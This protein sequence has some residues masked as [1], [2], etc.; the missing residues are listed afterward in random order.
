MF[1]DVAYSLI[2]FFIFALIVQFLELTQVFDDLA[3]R[4][5]QTRLQASLNNQPYFQ[6]MIADRTL[7]V[8]LKGSL[9]RFS[10][11]ADIVFITGESSLQQHGL[12]V[13]TEFARFLSAHAPAS[14]RIEVE[15][16]T[17]R[18]PVTSGRYKDNWEL[19]AERSLT[20]VRLFQSL[21]QDSSSGVRLN[22][23]RISAIGYGEFQPIEKEAVSSS[24]NRRV[25]IRLD[26][27]SLTGSDM[28]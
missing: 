26:Y 20:V 2:L 22:P 6:K 19:S 17:D 23:S 9:Q 16:H 12:E 5:A 24:Q 11:A 10:F 21:A 7:S 8:S 4:Q 14:I 1:S 25:E 15:G 18:Q 27:S 13:L 3:R 28:K